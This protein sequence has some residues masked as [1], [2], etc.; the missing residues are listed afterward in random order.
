MSIYNQNPADVLKS[1]NS[2]TEGLSNDEVKKRQEKYGLNQMNQSKPKSPLIIFLEQYK[3][4]LVIV[5]ICAALI[6]AV[7]GEFVSTAVILVVIT[8]NAIL[9]TIQ[10]L[11]A[12]KSLESLQKLSTPH[13]KVLR[14]GQVEEISSDQLTI[15][16]IVCVEAGD[17]IE[18]DGRILEAANLQINESALTGESLPQEKSVTALEGEKPLADQTNMVFS[19]GLVTNGTGKYVVSAI[20]MDTQIGHIATMIENASERKTPLQKSLD[21]F[22]V[23]LT[24][25]ICAICA[26][27]LCI[28]VVF[29]HENILDA[30]L[31]AVALAVAAIPE[32][33]GSI[34]TI[35]LSISTQKMVKENAIIKQLNAVESLGCVSI[36]C[37]DK[38]GTLT[39]NKMKVMDVFANQVAFAPEALDASDH[40]HDVLL[41]ECLLCNNAIYREDSQIGDPTE[42]ALLELFDN[43]GKKDGDYVV[44]TE[45]LS[46]IPFDSS[47]KMMSINS[48]F[49]LYTKGAVDE[50]LKRCTQIL[51]HDQ[52]RPITEEDK[53]L[54]LSKN[55]EYAKK[56]LR[57]LGFAYKNMEPKE[58]DYED[59]NDLCFVG[60]VAQMDP[61]R[62]ESKDAVEKC[63]IA[64]IKPIMITGDH[65]I[66]AQSIAQ[67]IG[68]FI[69]G[70]ICLEG[71]QLEKMNDE[72]LDQILPKVS[73]YARV[74]PEHKIR[75]VKAWQ[76]RK[77]IVAMTGDGVNDAPAL[78]QSD[79]GVAMGI[80][81]TEVSKDAASMIL[82]DDNF[83]TI[84]KAVITGR[85]VYANIKNAITYL[86]SGNFSAILAVVFTSVLFLPTPFTAVHLLFINLITDSLP[87]I[88]IGM[89]KG[90]D[91]IL[92]Q[93]PRKS[94][95]SILNRKT[96][97]QI[98][99]EGLIIFIFVM[100]AYYLGLQTSASLASTM[101]FATLC[102]S[103][104]LHGFSSR[105]AL[106]LYKLSINV[107]S[108][109]AFVVGAGL[110]MLILLV[111]GLHGLFTIAQDLTLTHI[112]WIVLCALGSFIC[113]Q[114]VRIIKMKMYH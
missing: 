51:I 11:K 21:E 89:E 100:A 90:T 85:N 6:S 23:K 92:R 1:F 83:S 55:E 97:I 2:S 44:E 98:G 41:K 82:M 59:E 16:D 46:E 3:D 66:T 68:I 76:K 88:A 48:R 63:R 74:A 31:I 15:G 64:G 13:V 62:E 32:A 43:Y 56:G 17:V 70:D 99:S 103:R 79:I 54:I 24:I 50:L 40:C 38:T 35:V 109:L 77:E 58:L 110:L 22:S 101:A 80:T 33:L 60:M 65:A 112:G 73:V 26:I 107:Y 84:V 34:V 53:D 95:D 5:L 94:D 71:A 39:Q 45:R 61:P 114:I 4:L 47:R 111:P 57:V 81:G 36:I 67:Q 8:I 20:A 52:K 106:P 102:L 91:D 86:L 14:N 37:S 75:I 27:I 72:E 10:T 19:S 18:G 9:G 7:S 12:R 28:N 87:A 30:L 69:E 42:I 96:M 104:L 105:S 29:A 49:H 25:S 93:K 78:K 113:V 108:C